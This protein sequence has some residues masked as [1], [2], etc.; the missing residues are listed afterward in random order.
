MGLIKVSAT[1]QTKAVAGAIAGTFRDFKIA[2]AQA[3]GPVA[4]NQA[5]KAVVLA[6]SFLADEG[7]QI[8]VFPE[9]IDVEIDGNVRT[10][11][12]LTVVER[13]TAEPTVD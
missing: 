12:K 13:V 10:A 3:I 2:E 6:R 9:P 4:V 7:I 8:M 1:S 11:V 5:V